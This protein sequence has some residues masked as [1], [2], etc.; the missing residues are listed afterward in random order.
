[1]RM[2]ARSDQVRLKVTEEVTIAHQTRR[3]KRNALDQAKR[4]LQRILE[5]RDQ[6]M[7]GP[8]EEYPAYQAVFEAEAEL[9][10]IEARL[11]YLMG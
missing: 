11:R 8:E 3:A 6:G 1:M 2:Q 10:Q 9:V 5:L 4:R 7:V